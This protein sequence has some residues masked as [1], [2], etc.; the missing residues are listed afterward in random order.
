MTTSPTPNPLA[1][2]FFSSCYPSFLTLNET[3][4][5]DGSVNFLGMHLKDTGSPTLT[6]DVFDKRKDF[7]FKVVRYPHLDS[8]IPSSLAYGV[9]IGQL[10]RFTRIC[11][12]PLAFIRNAFDVASTL[13]HQKASL[14]RLKETFSSFCRQKIRRS[15]W[16]VS[17]SALVCFFKDKL[18]TQD[19]GP[20][21]S[22]GLRWLHETFPFW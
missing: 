11:S 4:L 3:T 12:T 18:L 2:Q 9:F 20:T 5:E 19:T 22:I 8:A 15:R 16:N 14:L 13:G 7:P 17:V 21:E 1:D 10:H 6:V